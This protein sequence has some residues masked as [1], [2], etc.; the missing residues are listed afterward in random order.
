MIVHAIQLLLLIS[1]FIYLQFINVSQIENKQKI[2][3]KMISTSALFACIF[4]FVDYLPFEKKWAYTIPKVLI[5]LDVLSILCHF[6][7]IGRF[8]K[9][10]DQIKNIN[11]KKKKSMQFWLS[12]VFIFLFMWMIL[13]ILFVYYYVPIPWDGFK[14]LLRKFKKQ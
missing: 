11:E 8:S 13:R 5:V 7:I 9:N 10:I 12:F 14:I 6:I 3:S 4:I 2:I 1:A